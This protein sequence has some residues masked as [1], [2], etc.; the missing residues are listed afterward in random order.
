MLAVLGVVNSPSCW[1]LPECHRQGFFPKNH[2]APDHAEFDFWV[3][4]PG[5]GWYEMCELAGFPDYDGVHAAWAI[6]LDRSWLSW[7]QSPDSLS[8]RLRAV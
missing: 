5:T 4:C 2:V 3:E 1:S 6:E 8:A 7:D